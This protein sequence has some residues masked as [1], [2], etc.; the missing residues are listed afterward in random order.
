[1]STI[2]G[3][4]LRRSTFVPGGKRDLYG[5]LAEKLDMEYFDYLTFV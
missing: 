4:E 2:V 5:Y 3:I 1:M